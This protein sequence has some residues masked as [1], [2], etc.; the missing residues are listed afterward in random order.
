MQYR[1]S[2]PDLDAGARHRPQARRRSSPP[3]RKPPTVN[4]DWIEPAR[5]GADA[6]RPGR[7]T[8]CSASA[9]RRLASVLNTVISGAPITQ[10]RDDIYLVDV[11]LRANDEQ[12]VSLDYLTVDPG[13]AAQWRAPYRSASSRP[14]NMCKIIPLIVAARPRSDTHR[15][16]RCRAWVLPE[17]VTT[18]LDA[19]DRGVAE[20]LAAGLPDRRRRYRRGKCQVAGLGGRRRADHARRHAHWS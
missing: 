15:A 5:A 4:F 19:A 2:G 13:S 8:A 14:S 11:V 12:R 20:E 1:V 16:G 9:R 17:S 18:K 6:D 7:G 10:V 3:I